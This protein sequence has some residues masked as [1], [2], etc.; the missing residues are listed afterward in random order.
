MGGGSRIGRWQVQGKSGH[1]PPRTQIRPQAHLPLTLPSWDKDTAPPW[2]LGLAIPPV[3]VCSHLFLHW[4]QYRLQPPLPY[5]PPRLI[6]GNQA[7]AQLQSLNGRA[8][9]STL[10][11]A[12][13]QCPSSLATLHVSKC[14]LLWLASLP[15]SAPHLNGIFLHF[16]DIKEGQESQAAAQPL[17]CGFGPP[18]HPPP[19][20]PLPP[21]PGYSP[22]PLLCSEVQPP[23]FSF[24]SA[25]WQLWVLREF[26]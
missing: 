7:P 20:L 9:G 2:P 14:L 13:L 17:A 16:T 21:S 10:F 11:S 5:H 19:D 26:T 18:P 8:F 6:L 1:V 24:S 25:A 3:V 12:F 22:L 15:A 23:G 4:Q